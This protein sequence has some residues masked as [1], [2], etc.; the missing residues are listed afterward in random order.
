MLKLPAKLVA[1]T[2]HPVLVQKTVPVM[3]ML[4]ASSDVDDALCTVPVTFNACF[5]A[6][7]VTVL[8]EAWM[9]PLTDDVCADPA[10]LSV[11]TRPSDDVVVVDIVP[12]RVSAGASRVSGDV[13]DMVPLTV[14]ASALRVSGEANRSVPIIDVSSVT[15]IVVELA[16]DISTV[17]PLETLTSLNSRLECENRT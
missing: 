3:A 9:V 6:R 8:E 7:R 4:C 13:V 17:V 11:S 2:R 12:L 1:F 16:A 15:L 10:P 5:E 14:S